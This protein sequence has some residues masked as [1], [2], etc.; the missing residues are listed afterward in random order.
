MNMFTEEKPG[1]SKIGRRRRGKGKSI[2][3]KSKFEEESTGENINEKKSN[4]IRLDDSHL[5]SP[6]HWIDQ[7]FCRNELSCLNL[8]IETMKLTLGKSSIINNPSK[9]LR[10][11]Y[12]GGHLSTCIHVLESALQSPPDN[13]EKP[14]VVTIRGT[15]GGKTR[16]FEELRRHLNEGDNEGVALS[17]TFNKKLRGG[18]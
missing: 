9:N 1:G 5:L 17:I 6:T 11:Q 14:L 10:N 4:H 3:A 13:R 2:H 15:G 16:L 7:F 18:G 12:L 8:S